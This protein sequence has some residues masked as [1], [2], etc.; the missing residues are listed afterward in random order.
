M[1]TK[2]QRWLW[3][4]ARLSVLVGI[5]LLSFEHS[6]VS[7]AEPEESVTFATH[8]AP[9]LQ[10]NCQ[11][12]HRPGS[13]GPMSLLTYEDARPW[14][15]RIKDRVAGRRMPPWPI[16]TTLGIQEFKNDISLTDE[17]VST[18]VQWV[19]AGAPL[20]DRADL[21][22]PV[23]WPEYADTWRY[24]EVFNR[25][26]DLVIESPS[27]T[28]IPSGLD[29]WPNPETVVE[30]LA[31]E[32]WIK[33][34]EI[35]P[36]NPESRYVFHHAN[37]SLIQ[38]GERT[39]LINSAAGK[40]GEIFPDD[41]GKLIKP[42]ATVRFGMHFYPIGEEVE[43]VMVLGLWLYPEGEGPQFETPGQVSFR[44]D[45]STGTGGFPGHS[46][47]VAR[48]GD[49]L[50]PP[51][52]QAMYRGVYV[53]DRPARIHDLRGHMHLR[54]KYQMVEAV[55]PDGRSEVINKLNWDHGWHTTF[56]YEDHVRPL[57]PKGTMLILTS[58]F[59]N[60]TDNHHNPDPDQW[61]VAGSRTVDEMAHIWIGITYFDNEEDFQRLV[62][63]RER[64]PTDE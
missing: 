1:K 62:T 14:A 29:Q 10:E 52:S 31:E 5:G 50:I 7:A 4:G 26:P 47:E 41:A 19:D 61:V 30:G 22:P 56:V 15:A 53:M 25:P 42:G 54:G 64:R 9:I 33:A 45:M 34:I 11:V 57:L 12:C 3:H 35:K 44:T 28:V 17:E 63:E 23:E 59:D 8:V 27:Y 36:G 24:E 6:Q 51:H 43:A 58:V 21:P 60:T 46:K 38:D 13:I 2:Y 40:E 55:Y 16:D 18:I 49:L 20:G 37:P 39:G 32:R 48:R